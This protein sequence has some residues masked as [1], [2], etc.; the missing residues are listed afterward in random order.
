MQREGTAPLGVVPLHPTP[1]TLNRGHRSAAAQRWRHRVRG[2]LEATPD[3]R[4]LPSSAP[5]RRPLPLPAFAPSSQPHASCRSAAFAAAAAAGGDPRLS[6]AFAAA[7]AAGGDPR[8]SAAFAAAAA[9]GGDPRLSGATRDGHGHEGLHVSGMDPDALVKVRLFCPQ[10][11]RERKTLPVSA[12][13][14]Y[15]DH[16][17]T[18]LK[19][20]N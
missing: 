9:A 17:S 15:K 11:Q 12:K 4:T 2:S 6:S 20:R 13:P 8:L 1:Y 3:Y 18:S 19:V 5:D 14:P 10:P 16:E 7:A